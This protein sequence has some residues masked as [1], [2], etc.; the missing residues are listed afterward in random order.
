VADD[1]SG[2]AHPARVT[3]SAG[4]LRYRDTGAGCPV[5]L[6]HGL[7]VDGRLWRKVVPDVA[8]RARVIVP[9]LPLGAHV[10]PMDPD[11]DLR[12]PAVADLV[13]ELLDHLS[14]DRVILVGNDTGG[15]IAQMIA[16]RHP[17]RVR[18]LVLTPCDAFDNFL[19]PVLRYT[20][21]A[22]RVPGGVRLAVGALRVPAIRRLPIALGWLARHPIPEDVIDGWLAP[23]R[24]DRAV[25]RDLGKVL[26]GVSREQTRTAAAALRTFP[27][28]QLMVWADTTRLFPLE[29]GRR[30]AAQAPDG[31]LVVV[32]DSLALVPE[33]QPAPLVRALGD[34]LGELEG[35]GA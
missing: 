4:P 22:A 33:D 24:G 9:D 14:L 35:G 31:R 16:A 2:T 30:L 23:A 21:V 11:A 3:L 29:H 7:L 6:L 19:P 10:E 13:V 32:P 1:S 12:P 26:R 8:R 15:A 18:A 20:Q 17:D 27:R 5:L 25:R 34:L 28:P